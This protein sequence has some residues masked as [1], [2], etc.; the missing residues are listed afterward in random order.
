M[1][2]AGCDFRCEGD[3]PAMQAPGPTLETARLI[4][5]PIASEDL[6]GF[7]E[8]H[9]DEEA[10]R[11]IGGLQPRSVVWR[12]MGTKAGGWA[13]HGF[14]FFSVI[15]KEGGRWIG[16][17]GP[18]RP[19]GW[20][21]TEV[22]WGLL[23]HA[24]GKGYATEG[25]TAAIDWAFDHLAWDEV[26]HVIAPENVRSQATARRLGSSNRGQGVLP[27]PHEAAVIDVWGQTKAEWRGRKRS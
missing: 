17:I 18:W 7:C 24:W 11:F 26:V 19:E 3:T 1:A 14:S 2:D 9:A 15:E 25:A 5:R 27:A 12:N 13:L 23:R 21:G 10:S 4:L 8:L 6:D 22:G 16:Q 20:P